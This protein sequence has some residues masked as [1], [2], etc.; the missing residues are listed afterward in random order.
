MENN[1]F[2]TALIIEGGGMRT[3]FTSGVLNTL[4]ENEIYF[5]FATGVSAGASNLVNYL[6]RDIKRVK[7]TFTSFASS[8]EFGGWNSFLKG[9]GYFNSDYIYTEK[10]LKDL[11]FDFEKFFSNPA[12]FIIP[13]FD[14][15]NGKS[16]YFTNENVVEKNDIFNAVRASSTYPVLMPK[17]I[18]NEIEFF[19]G[20]LC[21]DAGILITKVMQMGF[22]KVFMI[23][24]HEK[25]YRKTK[26]KHR[27]ALKTYFRNKPKVYKAISERYLAYNR[28]MDKID[29]MEDKNL[30]Y[31]IRPEA[32][33]G[34]MTEN[35]VEVLLE[36]YEY[37][38]NY[39]EK[40]I[41]KIKDFLGYKI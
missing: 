2:D 12:K 4:L 36:K 25:G 35:N 30:A 14:A 28:V 1:I 15:S 5:D 38:K 23:A 16:Y 29:D 20:G 21:E 22:K 9:D 40:Q 31:V 8:K 17:T 39:S 18:V 7:N 37:G 19:D 41:Q 11:S 3:S 13:A 24:S 32:P 27:R 10:A 26:Q 33:L 34:S 6:S